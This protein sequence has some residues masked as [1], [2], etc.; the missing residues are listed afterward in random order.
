VTDYVPN[1]PECP[2]CIGRGRAMRDMG[3]ER[4][5]LRADWRDCHCQHPGLAGLLTC[6]YCGE[7]A[8]PGSQYCGRTPCIDKLVAQLPDPPVDQACYCSDYQ[9]SG[10]PCL[11]GKC[12]NVP[13]KDW[14]RVPSGRIPVVLERVADVDWSHTPVVVPKP[15]TFTDAE[16]RE[17]SLRAEQSEHEPGGCLMR[18]AT[19]DDLERAGYAALTE[20]RH[21]LGEELRTEMARAT[22]PMS[23]TLDAIERELRALRAL[24]T[25]VTTLENDRYVTT[26]LKAID[27]AREATNGR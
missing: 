27:E 3:D 2:M 5:T 13:G 16:G 19:P 22:A 4:E 25:Y 1:N 6:P 20:V 15:I 23:S 12:P 17:W 18:D 9:S 21:V 14:T 7:Y 8:P 24:Y 11:P 10:L 26:L